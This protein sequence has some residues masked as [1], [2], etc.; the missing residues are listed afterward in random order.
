MDLQAYLKRIGYTG[1]IAA[2]LP[3]LRDIIFAHTCSIPFE[4]LDIL[5]GHPILLD[6]E[7]LESK[8]VRDCR[9]GYCFEQNALLLCVLR[10]I[11][12]SVTPLSA[13]VRLN[14]PRE[15]VPPRTHLFL[16]VEIDGTP[17]LADVGVGG[18]SPT[19][20]FQLDVWVVEQPT[21]HEMRRIVCEQHLSSLRYFH[22]AKLG[23]NWVDIHEFTYETMPEIDREVGNWWTS[24]HANSK[25][26]KNL[27]VALAYPDGTRISIQ[28]H[29]FNH[30]RGAEVIEQFEIVEFSQLL[31]V[32]GERFGIHLPVNS[33][34][35][36]PGISWLQ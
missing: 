22:Q 14:T 12:F 30:R 25:F 16:S 1:S 21:P 20:P 15:I 8:L 36:V 2:T 34:L 26:R 4:N 23:D 32:L 3:V 29:E 17:W 24:T 11:G 31:S 18:L 33:T 19:G 35:S 28:N 7:S 6:S 9:G 13:R 27:F 10:Q 5:M